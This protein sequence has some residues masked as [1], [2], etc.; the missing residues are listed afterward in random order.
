MAAEENHLET[1]TATP[2]GS[3]AFLSWRD[4]NC[5]LLWGIVCYFIFL[6]FLFLD[7][8]CLCVADGSIQTFEPS[9]CPSVTETLRTCAGLDLRCAGR[10]EDGGG[11][12]QV[13]PEAGVVSEIIQGHVFIPR[14]LVHVSM[15][16]KCLGNPHAGQD[17]SRTKKGSFGDILMVGMTLKRFIASFS[18][19]VV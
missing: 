10:K 2:Q 1:H 4:G 19:S 15:M 3:S 13:E 7:V 18:V 12:A 5:R 14:F 9:N 6:V 11:L 16:S 17:G 8:K